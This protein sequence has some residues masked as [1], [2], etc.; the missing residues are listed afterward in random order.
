[1]VR[2]FAAQ[3]QGETIRL[4]SSPHQ[5]GREEGSFTFPRQTGRELLCLSD[6]VSPKSLGRMY[7]V[8][9]FVVTC[10]RD[11]RELS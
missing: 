1:M 10:G 9:L 7:Y 2:F 6:F 11:I 5:G 3:S 4:Y 8:A